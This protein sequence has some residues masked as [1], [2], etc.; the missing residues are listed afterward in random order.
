MIELDLSID[1]KQQYPDF[2][3]QLGYNSSFEW[4]CKNCHII[5]QESEYRNFQRRK[6]KCSCQYN[7]Q[8]FQEINQE[9]SKV[10]YTFLY[11]ESNAYNVNEKG[12]IDLKKPILVQ[13]LNCHKKSKEYYYN[14]LKEHKRCNCNNT[15]KFTCNITTQEFIQK[16]PKLNQKNFELLD[17]EFHGRNF[18]YHIK[19]NRCGREDIRWGITLIDSAILCKYCDNG[20]KNEQLISMALDDLSIKYIREYLVDYNHHQHRFDFYLPNYNTMIEYNGLQHYKP[21]E[22]FGGIPQ[23]RLRQQRDL[24]KQQY[25]QEHNLNLIVFNYRQ[26]SQKILRQIGL[27]FNDQSQKT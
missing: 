27:I 18:K 14:I 11:L 5:H 22:Y 19:C 24:E 15:K 23:F 8:K 2:F 25:C 12:I 3:K 20:S 7:Q 1:Y 6:I 17:T 16:W 13:C 9:L 10:N 26:T 21:I 4:R